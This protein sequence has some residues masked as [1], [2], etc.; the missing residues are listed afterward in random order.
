M[1]GF[2]R[3]VTLPDGSKVTV[4]NTSEITNQG[5]YIR[6]AGKGFPDRRTSSRGDFVAIVHIELPRSLTMQQIKGT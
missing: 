2:T 4:K 1:L 3:E 5:Q 6:T